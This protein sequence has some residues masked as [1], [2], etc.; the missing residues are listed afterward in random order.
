[1]DLVNRHL[2]P[3]RTV[4]SGVSSDAHTWNL[5]YLQL[6][7]EECGHEVVNLGACVPD[8]DIVGACL[9]HRPDLLVV[10]S[11]NGHGVHDAGRLIR[12]VRDRHELAPMQ[13]VLGGKLGV[14]GPLRPDQVGALSDAGY[15]RVFAEDEGLAPFVEHVTTGVAAAVPF[16]VAV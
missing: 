16:P 11:V 10:S 2:H 3:P 9:R 7:L 5:V 6:V 12:A 1:M 4:L 13:A 8:V 15:D 14:E